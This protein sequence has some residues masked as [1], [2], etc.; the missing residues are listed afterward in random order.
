[1]LNLGK[2]T[3][4]LPTGPLVIT[5]DGAQAVKL[6]RELGADVLVPMHFESWDHFKEQREDLAQSFKAEGLDKEVLWLE[7]GKKTKLV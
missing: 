4:P 1:M 2:A 7:P 3:A 5:M 6:F